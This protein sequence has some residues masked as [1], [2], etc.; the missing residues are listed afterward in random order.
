MV[1]NDAVCAHACSDPKMRLR[2]VNTMVRNA[3]CHRT[4]RHVELFFTVHPF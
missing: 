2:T 1:L 3:A 4:P